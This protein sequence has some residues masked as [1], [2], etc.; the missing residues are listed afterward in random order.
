MRR[1][2]T[3]S[4]G[5]LLLAGCGS[6]RSGSGM[7][8]GTITYNGQPVNGAALLLYPAGGG[9][10]ILIPVTQEG[11]FR[12][13][14]LPPGEYKVVVQGTAGSPGPPTQGMS[15]QKLAEVKEKLEA[16]KTPATIKFP[17]KYKS[18]ATTDLKLTVIAGEQTLNLELKD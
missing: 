1:I 3:I 16:M 8:S 14:D 10:E 15:P 12:T 18:Q 6:N 13:S 17:D 7:V 5:L 4:I 9:A 2:V 11:E